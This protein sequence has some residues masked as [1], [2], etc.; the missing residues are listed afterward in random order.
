MPSNKI[1]SLAIT[2]RPR[3]GV[4]D[5]D[6]AMFLN[7]VMDR[8]EFRHVIT[9]KSEAE[10]HIHAALYLR[11]ET[12]VSAFGQ[13]MKRKFEKIFEERKSIWKYAYK[14]T[15]MYNDDFLKNYLIGANEGEGAKSEDECVV[16]ESYLPD[17]EVRK[18]YY[19]DTPNA[20]KTRPT[21]D[22]YYLKLEKLYY[23]YA[24]QLDPDPV[25]GAMNQRRLRPTDRPTL[26]QIEEFLS[27]IMYRQR[28]INVIQDSRK[29]RRVCKNLRCFIMKATKY[30]WSRGDVNSDVMQF[31]EYR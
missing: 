29:M 20:K 5:E 1:K 7:M 26:E 4:T 21:G 27:D 17:E 22:A 31:P 11:K 2:L 25:N 16:V 8:T 9:E 24:N 3:G 14:G 15:Q 18:T 30:C 13:L 19:S 12:T 28:R 6:I 23:E 10:R